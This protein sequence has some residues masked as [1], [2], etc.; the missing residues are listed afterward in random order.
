MWQP[1]ETAPRDG[2]H[3]LICDRI[4]GHVAQCYYDEYGHLGD[5]NWPWIF[6]DDDCNETNA[7]GADNTNL[8]WMPLPDPPRIEASDKLQRAIEAIRNEI[9]Q[10]FTTSDA[11][12]EDANDRAFDRDYIGAAEAQ[13]ESLGIDRAIEALERVIKVLEADN[14]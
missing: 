12:R 1:I 4:S 2:T 3:F 13:R 10:L 6:F 7:F 8:Y 14:D 5:I 11:L 9:E